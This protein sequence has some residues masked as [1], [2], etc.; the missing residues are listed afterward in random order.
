MSTFIL[1]LHSLVDA[2]LFKKAHLH[3]TLITISTLYSY[4]YYSIMLHFF[5]SMAICPSYNEPAQQTAFPLY[6]LQQ[7]R[8]GL[9]FRSFNPRIRI[10]PETPLCFLTLAIF[11]YLHRSGAR[12]PQPSYAKTS[13]FSICCH[14]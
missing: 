11:E 13:C 4:H 9:G 10:K 1:H 5:R 2:Y 12:F 8:T 7:V 14:R 6:V 3:S